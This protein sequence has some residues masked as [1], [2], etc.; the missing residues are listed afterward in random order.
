MS[1]ER[2]RRQMRHVPKL[3]MPLRHFP[4]TLSTVRSLRDLWIN[5]YHDTKL[6]FGPLDDLIKIHESFYT[7][8]KTSRF[9][10][11]SSLFCSWGEYAQHIAFAYIREIVRGEK[12]REPTTH[13]LS[14][15]NTMDV[16]Y[17]SEWVPRA[18]RDYAHIWRRR[19]SKL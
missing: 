6:F 8:F 10:S 14:F 5:R 9:A 12:E 13:N 17:D 18:R 15:G 19:R 16:S 3:P 1:G 2:G 7:L 4:T 11:F